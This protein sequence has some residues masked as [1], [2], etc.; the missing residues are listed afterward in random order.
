MHCMG[1]SPAATAGGGS[2]GFVAGGELWG[3]KR[4]QTSRCSSSPIWAEFGVIFPWN[5]KNLSK[6]QLGG[7][8]TCLDVFVD[9]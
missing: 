6:K 4:I 2:A 1:E 7:G 5:K 3:K 9:C 8:F